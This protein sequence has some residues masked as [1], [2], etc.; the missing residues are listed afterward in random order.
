MRGLTLV[1]HLH[2]TFRPRGEPD[3]ADCGY[4]RRFWVAKGKY[5][6]IRHRFYRKGHY[7]DVAPSDP[8][9]ACLTEM[10][11]CERNRMDRAIRQ[12]EQNYLITCLRPS[13][14]I[15]QVL[16]ETVKWYHKEGFHVAGQDV[17][18]LTFQNKAG[19]RHIVSLRLDSGGLLLKEETEVGFYQLAR[20]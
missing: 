15:G 4:Q 16:A 12:P 7:L 1:E 6:S 17:H 14:D 13:T 3:Y 10:A 19:E 20:A 9:I 5:D 8:L 2:D 11:S 18:A